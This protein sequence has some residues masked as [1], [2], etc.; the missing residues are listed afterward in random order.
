MSKKRPSEP[1]RRVR[2]QKAKTSEDFG[3]VPHLSEKTGDHIL[4]VRE[5]A[6][7]FENAGVPRTERSIINWCHPNPQGI[8]RLDCHLDTNERKYYIT[9]SSVNAVIS[10]ERN[11]LKIQAQTP[12][13]E[14]NTHSSEGFRRVSEDFGNIPNDSERE[15]QPGTAANAKNFETQIRDLQ[16]TNAA[17]DLFIERLEKT[18]DRLIE[19]LKETSNLLGAMQSKVKQLESP[20]M[21]QSPEPVDNESEARQMQHNP[22]SSV[23]PTDDIQPETSPNRTMQ[24]AMNSYDAT[25]EDDE[26]KVHPHEGWE[27]TRGKRDCVKT[28]S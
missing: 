13:S 27:E 12:S 8:P 18:Q 9:P 6:K 4:T 24:T 11:K 23:Q 14:R 26:G 28:V 25:Q 2:K 15:P 3:R 10:E 1:F 22:E 17:K 16:I 5:V 7:D 19:N 20:E 21:G